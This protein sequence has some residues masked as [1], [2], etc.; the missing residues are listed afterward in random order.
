VE[1]SIEAVV[2]SGRFASVDEAMTRAAH[3]LLQELKQEARPVSA[4][5]IFGLGSI[6]AMREDA[7]LLDEIV[8]DAMKRR[9]EETWRD[10]SAQQGP[11]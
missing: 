5:A 7:A 4:R 2:Q 11:A 10:I 9:R 1:R 8:A 6:G 3:L